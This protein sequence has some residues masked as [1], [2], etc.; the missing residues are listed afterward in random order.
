[1]NVQPSITP[2][3][4]SPASPLFD[5]SRDTF[6]S[7]NTSFTT[8]ET[9]V[10]ETTTVTEVSLG[11]HRNGQYSITAMTTSAGTVAERCAFTEF[12][13]PSVQKASGSPIGNQQFQIANRFT[14]TGHEWDEA[15]GL[16]RSRIGRSSVDAEWSEFGVTIDYRRSEELCCK[17]ACGIGCDF[18][19]AVADCLGDFLPAPVRNECNF[20]VRMAAIDCGLSCIHRCDLQ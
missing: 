10:L 2:A 18:A 9:P 5:T 15:L 17:D 16:H 12:V 8:S 1:M 19:A 14:Y 4:F 13:Q 7:L 3:S 11:Y 20:G 6:K